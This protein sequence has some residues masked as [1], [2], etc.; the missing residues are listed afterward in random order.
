[1]LA[2]VLFALGTVGVLA[3]RN[4]VAIILSA[5]LMVQGVVLTFAAFGHW[6]GTARGQ[7]AGLTALA[8]TAVQAGCLIG[9]LIAGRW[10]DGVEFTEAEEPPADAP[11]APPPEGDANG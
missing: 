11:A 4:P 10:T 3:R 1:M 2:A 7:A 8:A 6:H 9:L 5:G